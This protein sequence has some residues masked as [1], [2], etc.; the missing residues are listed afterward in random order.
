MLVINDKKIH[1]FIKIFLEPTH[2]SP[3]A[4]H[5]IFYQK[6]FFIETKSSIAALVAP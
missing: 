6:P 3:H 4:I 1:Y 2:D 5:F